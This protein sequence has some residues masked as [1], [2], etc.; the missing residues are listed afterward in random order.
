M[1]APSLESI[2]SHRRE[3]LA[4]LAV[5]AVLAVSIGAAFV[6]GTGTG[7][8]TR[9]V[10]QISFAWVNT[11]SDVATILPLGFAFGAGMVAAVNPCGF[12]M[13]PAY[14]GLY[15]GS[16]DEQTS[17]GLM[18]SHLA[19]AFWVSGMVTLGFIVLFGIAGILLSVATST[20]AQYLPWLGL[21]IGA[22]LVIVAGMMLAGR[23]IYSALGEQVAD[24]LGGRARQAGSRGYFAYGLGYGAASLSCTFPIFI[25]V[26][27]STLAVDGAVAA[28]AQFVLYALGMG[29][30]ITVLTVGTAIFKS[31]LVA[32]I[33]GITRYVQP[34][35]GVLLLA[36]GGY[37]VYYWLSLGGLLETI[38]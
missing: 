30:I 1:T 24:R 19:R 11:L 18:T 28:M 27:G 29:A 17:R 34:A 22:L 13:L 32:N 6:T 21:G 38:L 14:L 2:R 8:V 12:A 35:S 33:R 10:E 7:Q 20:I 3:V 4:A 15:L 26:V 5:V 36:A 37:I 9:G 31:A 23:A 25:A 16:R